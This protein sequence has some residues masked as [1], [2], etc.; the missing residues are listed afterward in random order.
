MIGYLLQIFGDL[1]AGKE[2]VA[3]NKGNTGNFAGE[4]CCPYCDVLSKDIEDTINGD[5]LGDTRSRYFI[6]RMYLLNL[7]Y[8]SLSCFIVCDYFV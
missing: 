6:D 2:T 7:R 5:K 3:I 4:R 8:I 1:Q